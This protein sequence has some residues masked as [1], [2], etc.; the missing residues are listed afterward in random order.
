MENSISR[1]DGDS[2]MYHD[3]GTIA[4]PTT[5]S[6]NTKT[7]Q[8]HAHT[9][10]TEEHT[11]TINGLWDHQQEAT[12][13]KTHQNETRRT[14]TRPTHK[15]MTQEPDIPRRNR[16]EDRPQ[17]TGPKTK[18]TPMETRTGPMIPNGNT[19]HPRMSRGTHGNGTSNSNRNG[20]G[21]SS[22]R[23]NQIG[24]WRQVVTVQ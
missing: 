7:V 10:N 5:Y 17:D 20:N 18:E 11:A 3:R 12:I 15:E 4:P 16:T 19:Q 23:K 6:P 14:Q 9:R 13:D 22:N 8:Q 2:R 24:W 21:N 1:N